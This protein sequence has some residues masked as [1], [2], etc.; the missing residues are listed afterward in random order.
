MKVDINPRGNGACPL[1]VNTSNCR[2][3]NSLSDAVVDISN[4]DSPSIE[5]VV[6]SCPLF[7][8]KA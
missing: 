3:K 5:I 7:K 4:P 8:E 2:I 6:Y 1:C